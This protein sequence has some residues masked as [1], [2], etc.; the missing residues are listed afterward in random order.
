MLMVFVAVPGGILAFHSPP[1]PPR[2]NAVAVKLLDYLDGPNLA[3]VDCRA[4]HRRVICTNDIGA[5][6]GALAQALDEYPAPGDCETRGR[7]T[8]CVVGTGSSSTSRS[9]LASPG[10]AE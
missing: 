4:L 3:S 7:R 2:I 5:D 8:V 6:T 1:P 9:Q 10:T